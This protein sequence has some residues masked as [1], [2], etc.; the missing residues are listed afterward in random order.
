MLFRSTLVAV[1]P[2]LG[3][4]LP[5]LVALDSRI[6][7]PRR[8]CTALESASGLTASRMGPL[9][10]LALT[11]SDRRSRCLG[12]LSRRIRLFRG[13]SLSLGSANAGLSLDLCLSSRSTCFRL[14]RCLDF[15]FR[16]GSVRSALDALALLRGF[17]SGLA[18]L[19]AFAQCLRADP[20]VKKIP[21][22]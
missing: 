6:R 18:G 5:C 14:S 9:N 20:G 11:M 4:G 3:L 1:E 7:G 13:L 19:G 22:C 15:F 10:N 17:S 21:I 12:G 8:I 2:D 16:S